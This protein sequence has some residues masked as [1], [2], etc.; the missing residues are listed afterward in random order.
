MHIM[1]NFNRFT[2]TSLVLYALP[3]LLV[4]AVN[5]SE[6]CSP[7]SFQVLI[8]VNERFTFFSLIGFL[9]DPGSLATWFS[10]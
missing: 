4:S 7:I 2:Q 8:Q 3:T 10:V 5:G 1:D 9:G 6:Y